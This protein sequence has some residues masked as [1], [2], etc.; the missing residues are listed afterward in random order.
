MVD[1][2]LLLPFYFNVEGS[3][4]KNDL[5]LLVL[6]VFENKNDPLTL[7]RY[8]S[9]MF[10]WIEKEWNNTFKNCEKLHTMFL[11][12]HK[13]DCHAFTVCLFVFLFFYCHIPPKN[14]N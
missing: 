9:G 10:A 6:T 1:Y 11:D 3:K 5:K 7:K 14:Q 4:N 2:D 12:E 8:Y 13:T